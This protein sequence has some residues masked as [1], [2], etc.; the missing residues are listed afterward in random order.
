MQSSS[1]LQDTKQ[2]N[3]VHGYDEQVPSKPFQHLKGQSFL[4]CKNRA[5]EVVYR[6]SIYSEKK[7]ILLGIRWVNL[8]IL[9]SKKAFCN[10]GNS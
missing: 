8:V 5:L 4:L 2:T 9:M 3:Y 6:I 7:S 10:L 1:L